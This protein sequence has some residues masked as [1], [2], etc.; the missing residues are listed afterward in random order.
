MNYYNKIVNPETG[1][2]VSITSKLGKQILKKYLVRQFGIHLRGGVP[3]NGSVVPPPP[4][5]PPPTQEVYDMLFL[6]ND[7]TVRP[8]YVDEELTSDIMLLDAYN[9]LERFYNEDTTNIE[10]FK[11]DLKE[12]NV[13]INYINNER[14]KFK[15][16]LKRAKSIKNICGVIERN[17]HNLIRNVFN[18]LEGPISEE[19]ILLFDTNLD[20]IIDKITE[21]YEYLK[22]TWENMKRGIP[23]FLEAA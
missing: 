15:F 3:E 20:K 14:K 10:D 19:H 2:I 5:P 9:M 6:G 16:W 13:S 11:N 1:K 23:V 18:G 7:Y 22:I 17:K 21:T 12:R 8:R 4:P